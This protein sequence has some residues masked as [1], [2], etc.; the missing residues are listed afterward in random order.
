MF[1]QKRTPRRRT[2]EGLVRAGRGR[3]SKEEKKK[4]KEKKNVYSEGADAAGCDDE[5]EEVGHA[6]FQVLYSSG[7]L[8]A[9]P[10]L[11]LRPS[12]WRGERK[13]W[14]RQQKIL[15]E[16]EGSARATR[17]HIRTQVQVQSRYAHIFPKIFHLLLRSG[18]LIFF[19][20]LRRLDIPAVKLLIRTSKYMLID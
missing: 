9:R 11:R 7:G 18:A 12:G 2:E 20:R 4:R 8:C 3:R 10:L 15:E 6:K 1:R 16:E 19:R 5:E 17:W 14:I 13:F